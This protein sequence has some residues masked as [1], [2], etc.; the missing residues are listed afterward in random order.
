MRGSRW[1]EG[2]AISTEVGVHT[3]IA[4][5]SPQ[6]AVAF[7][8]ASIPTL[9]ADDKVDG[10]RRDSESER[11]ANAKPSPHSGSLG[12]APHS[13]SIHHPASCGKHDGIICER[14]ARR[15]GPWRCPRVQ[16]AP[17]PAMLQ[18]SSSCKR[19]KANLN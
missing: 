15:P 4:T 2:A 6:S 10:E 1:I 5:V 17:R 18:Q 14:Q 11:S 12:G 8:W 13:P 7:R 16:D 9:A 19:K 3:G